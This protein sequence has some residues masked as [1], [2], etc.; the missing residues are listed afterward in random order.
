[1]EN[2]KTLIKQIEDDT[3]RWKNVSCL[4]FGRITVIKMAT[5]P[6]TIY[7]FIAI[8][9]KVSVAFFTELEQVILQSVVVVVVQSLIRV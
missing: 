9:V 5:L 6:K 7:R 8:P 3:N 1:M 2:W 4:S